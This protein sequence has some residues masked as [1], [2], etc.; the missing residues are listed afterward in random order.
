MLTRLLTAAALVAFATAPSFAQEPEWRT[1]TSLI[2]KTKYDG[3]AFDHYDHV[4]PDAPKGG[5]LN[6][7]ANG[8]FDSF[9]P[10]IVQGTPASG[11]NYQGGLLY[12]NLMAKAI[13]EPSASHPL[14]AKDFSYPDDYSS[15]TYRLNP[16]AKWHD[17]VPITAEDVVWSV[18]QLKAHSPQYAQY[19]GDVTEAVA[20]NERQVTFTFREKGNRELPLIMSDLPV[21]PK[22]WWTE[23]GKNRDFTKSSLEIPL[24]SGPYRIKSFSAGQSVTWERVEDY[25]AQD[26]PVNKGR[27]NYGTRVYRYFKDPNAIWQAFTKGGLEDIRLENRAQRWAEGYTTPARCKTTRRRRLL[28]SLAPVRMRVRRALTLAYNFEAFALAG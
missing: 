9:N 16:D 2:G 5:T 1:S 12:D 19:F 14:I 28:S 23:E 8:T 20:D 22:H 4:N 17:G 15:A 24:G 6:S 27:Y 25:W 26:L 3:R 7:A 13:D 18:E 21:L 10:F 11:L